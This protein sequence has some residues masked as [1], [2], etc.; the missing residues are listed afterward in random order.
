MYKKGLYPSIYFSPHHP[1]INHQPN[2]KSISQAEMIQPLSTADGMRSLG[3]GC[4]TNQ[5]LAI[6][7]TAT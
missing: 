2:R 6:P 3:I 7:R 4:Q 5:S 1:K